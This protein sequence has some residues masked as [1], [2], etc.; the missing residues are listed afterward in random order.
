VDIA[1]DRTLYSVFRSYA[2]TQPDCPWLTYE[3][4]VEQVSQWSYAKFLDEIHRAANLLRQFGIRNGD[5]INLHLANHP[6]YPLLIL[7]ASY[8]GAIVLPTS[9]S[10]TAEELHFFLQHSEAKLVVT[11]E[12]HLP[13]VV[14]ATRKRP[15]AIVLVRDGFSSREY[16]CFETE[17]GRQSTA[18]SNGEGSS[19]KVV[20]LLYTSGTTSRPKGVM[21]TNAN[22]VY[23]AEVFRAA[24]GLRGDDCH[25]IALPLYHS[26]AQCHALWPSLIAG[27]SVAVMFR[28]SASR[29]F[30]QAVKYHG[31][32]AALFGAPLRMLLN[33]PDRPTDRTHILRNVTFAQN[34]TSLQYEEWHRRF[35]APLQQ[36]W[37]MTEMAA[38][39]IMSPLTGDRRLHAMGRP[40]LG[41][42]SRIVDESGR[43]VPPD[44]PGQLITRGVP[45]RSL[46]KGYL[47]D[48]DATNKTIRYLDGAAW[49][50]SGDTATYDHDGFFYFVDRG[51]DMIKRSGLNISTSEV[52]SVI[53]TLEGVA[54]VCVCGI[55]DP[56]KDECVAAVIVKKTESDLTIDRIRSHCQ[57]NLAPYKIPQR[58]EFCEALPRTSVGKIRKNLVRQQLLAGVPSS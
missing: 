53:A 50:F 31:T 18:L 58:I 32:M 41:Y 49:L 22:F 56:T 16:P 42:E 39:P 52:E 33:Q 43:E 46:M 23:S 11:H 55:P 57:A 47:K 35:G 34:L 8:L 29:F 3:S 21:L 40:V 12:T 7:A 10:C 15:G 30:E 9:P 54:D 37:G 38:L 5:V 44:V 25:L 4:A 27:A 14:A 19:D 28:F 6:A 24:T 36:L 48:E 45:G 2:E 13:I 20:Q 17:M 26:A 1:G 51:R